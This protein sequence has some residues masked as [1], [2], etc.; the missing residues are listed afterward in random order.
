MLCLS[1]NTFLKQQTCILYCL[2]KISNLS[3]LLCILIMFWNASSQLCFIFFSLSIIMMEKTAA[4]TWKGWCCHLMHLV[5]H[6]DL[7]RW[8]HADLHW[9]CARSWTAGQFNIVLCLQ[10]RSLSTNTS[11]I[12]PCSHV[13]GPKYGTKSMFVSCSEMK[14]SGMKNY[15]VS[16]CYN[17]LKK[18]EKRTCRTCWD[19]VG[20]RFKPELALDR[21]FWQSL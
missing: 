19:N 2:I 9:T 4:K 8:W 7:L 1:E 14:I 21:V 11:F 6:Q 20:P 18:N 5:H 3:H 17:G 13:L 16:I 15:D 10:A 12:L